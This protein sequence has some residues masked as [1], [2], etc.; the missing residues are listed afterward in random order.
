M[1]KPVKTLDTD[2]LKVLASLPP[3]QAVVMLNLLRFR[4]TAKYD[5]A[6]QASCS[7]RDA[8]KRYS[9]ASLQTVAAVGG[10]VIFSGRAH[11][12][13]IGPSAEVWHQVFLVRYPSV[14]AFLSMLAMPE[15]RAA[16][17]HRTA[18]LEDSRLIPMT[19][20]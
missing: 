18:A 9:Q 2:Q 17:K 10:A 13:L 3:G 14:E 1:E 15:Y 20:Y 4:E 12:A 16:V 8:Y 11:A 5:D 7:G 19:A 6:A